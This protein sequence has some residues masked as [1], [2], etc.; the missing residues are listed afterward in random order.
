MPAQ[1]AGL[2]SAGAAPP[3]CPP[4]ADAFAE[5]PPRQP[6]Q[7]RAVSPL[8]GEAANLGGPVANISALASGVS[9]PTKLFRCGPLDGILGIVMSK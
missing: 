9:S 3:S 7:E 6:Q 5:G 1:P 2:D 4:A 8:R